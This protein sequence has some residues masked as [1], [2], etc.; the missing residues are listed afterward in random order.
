MTS[1]TPIFPDWDGDA[2]AL[3]ALQS[4]LA[5][6]VVLRDQFAKPLRTVAGFDVGFEDGDTI[7]RAAAV[8]MDADTLEVIASEIARLPTSM[9][10]IPD[11]LGFREL[12][13]LLAA[14]DRLPQ[15]PDLAFVDGHG[16]AHPHRV[17]RFRTDRTRRDRDAGRL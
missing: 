17:H 14:L 7:T 1:I 6:Q 8:L 2:A 3:H 16:I 13:A 11:L 5:T 9:P 10:D 12:P 15:A 4:E